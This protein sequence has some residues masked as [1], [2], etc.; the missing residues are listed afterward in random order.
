MLVATGED[1]AGIAG[2]AV[3]PILPGLAAPACPILARG[4]V[5]AVG[6]AVAGV[7]AA[8]PAAA[9][10]AAAGIVLELAEEPPPQAAAPVFRWQAGGDPLPAGAAEVSVRLTQPLLA[11]MA[12]EPRAILAVPQE[13]GL[14]VHLS[15]QTPHRAAAELA[16]LLGLAP[17]RVRVVAVDVGGAFG[18]KASLHPEEIFVAWAALRLGRPVKW[19]ASRAEEFL[20]APLGRGIALEGRLAVAADGGLAGLAARIRAP[21]GHWLTYSAAVPAWNAARILP[22]PYLCPA[23][24]ILAEGV[25][26]ATA[27]VGIYRGAG[28][29]EA[30]LLM[31]R[32]MDAAARRLSMDPVALRRR[33]LIPPAAFPFR[34]PT[35]QSLDSGDYGRLMD[36]ACAAAG[37]PELRAAQRRRRAA[38]ELV[39]IGVALFVEP[40]G[41]GGE[42]AR[43]TVRADGSAEL[44]TGASAQGQ[45]R[46]TAFAQIAAA[47]LGLPAEAVS[48]IHGDTAATPEGIGALASRSTAIGGSA[49]LEA[50]SALRARALPL[51]AG[52]MQCGE[53]ALVAAEGGFA[54]A[55]DPGR[56]VGWAALAREAGGSLSAEAVFTTPGEAWGAGC[57]IATLSVDRDTGVPRLEGLTW[58]DDA[59]V[60]V[61]P[62]LA[63]GQILGG[64][65]QGIGQALMERMVH[66][67]SGQVLTGSLMDYAV[68]R[69]TDM[70]PVRL[71]GQHTPAAVNPLG[72]KGVGESGA[73]GAPAAIL[74][75]AIDALAPLG[76]GDLDLPLTPESLWRAIRRAATPLPEQD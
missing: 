62:L 18:A 12:L 47:A 5:A 16:R 40:C 72:A 69:A 31:E 25:T 1:L 2:P 21:L 48:V 43:L 66:D 73:I 41:A 51:A 8:S 36:L 30:A 64:I 20:S 55:D 37:Y 74:N 19:T 44:A 76:V 61:N 4:R 75:A 45:G 10:D 71:A 46:E 49:I 13:G 63:E 24:G 23:V 14:T 27:A 28:R 65:A 38:G 50:A 29:P 7:V 70:P 59:G 33:N 34:T 54:R 11:P 26:T 56:R 6:Q 52:L 67:A 42:S 39:G 15:T 32:L 17:G 60:V 22:G 53:A 9:A 3:N 35:G 57:C 68:P 58:A